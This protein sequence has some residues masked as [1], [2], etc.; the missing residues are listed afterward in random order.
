MSTGKN[1]EG[2]FQSAYDETNQAL[3]VTGVPATSTATTNG[4]SLEEIFQRA[5]Q[6][7]TNTINV[8]GV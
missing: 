4:L 6:E 7:S 1:L 8:I 2:I 3:S 5:F